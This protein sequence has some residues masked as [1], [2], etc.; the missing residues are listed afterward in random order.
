MKMIVYKFV[1]RIIAHQY[2]AQCDGCGKWFSLDDENYSTSKEELAEYMNY[3]DYLLDAIQR[4]G[5]IKREDKIFCPECQ[6]K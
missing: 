6:K 1:R 5:W 4:F 2:F 3:A